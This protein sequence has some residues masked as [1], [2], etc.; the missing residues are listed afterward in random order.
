MNETKSR[1]ASD[2]LQL[3]YRCWEPEHP[4]RAE[5]F[6][7]HGYNEHI[8]RYEHV[9]AAMSAAGFRFH[10]MDLRGHGSS[11]GPR[12][13]TPSWDQF[14]RDVDLLLDQGESDLPSFIYGHSMGGGIVL[15]YAIQTEREI[16]GVIATGPT[17]RLGFTPSPAQVFMAKVIGAIFPGFT[18]DGNLELEALSRD[19]AI[20]VAYANDPLIH[21][22]I[23]ARLFLSML[24]GGQ[25][26]LQRAPQ[27]RIPLLLLHGSEDR[28]SDASASR[29]FFNAAGV[30]DKTL[31]IYDGY[32]HELHNEPE[33][34]E[35]LETITS[36]I[37]ERL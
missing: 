35:V 33:K 4:A 23:S 12:G 32:Y 28:L 16:K 2:G 36:W 19:P 9:A 29:E 3:H 34:M 5:V 6:F 31:K 7:I 1:T 11:E 26:A 37:S 22:K 15:S 18:Q 13:H 8:G 25:E 24:T 27:L 20:A 10:A 21:N 30:E 17:L 14:M